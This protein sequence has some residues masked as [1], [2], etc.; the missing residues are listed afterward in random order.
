MKVIRALP[1]I[2]IIIAVSFA[3]IYFLNKSTL[4]KSSRP[5]KEVE[6]TNYTEAIKNQIEIDDTVTIQGTPNLLTQVSQESL[7]QGSTSERKIDY[8]YVGLKEYG[9]DFVVRIK[10]GKLNAEM[11]TFTGRVMGLAQTEFG[12]RIKNSLNK[13]INFDESV[14]SQAANEL[15]PESKTQIS[16]KSEATFTN[17]TF[18]I[19]DEEVIEYST[20]F[21]TVIL[22]TAILGLFLITLFRKRIF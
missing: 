1:K 7:L 8:Y 12:T 2:I 15:D 5:I 9:Y 11:Q 14:N 10:P 16:Q 21:G 6:S 18:L 3:A 17:S 19:L 20:V 4:D 13:P 22:W